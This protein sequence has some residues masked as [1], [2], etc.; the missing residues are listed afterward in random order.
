MS[1]SIMPGLI[2]VSTNLRYC[3]SV[4]D[5]RSFNSVYHKSGHSPSRV[6]SSYRGNEI[7]LGLEVSMTEMQQKDWVV[8]V[9]DVD[10]TGDFR[11]QTGLLIYMQ[12]KTPDTTTGPIALHD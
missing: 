7:E 8:L 10:R 11:P 2:I 9:K 1:K 6:R 4:P 3:V 5:N 12:G